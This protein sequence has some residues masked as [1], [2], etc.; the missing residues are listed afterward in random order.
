[1]HCT[2]QTYLLVCL[3]TDLIPVPVSDQGVA[4]AL[5]HEHSFVILI[6]VLR[7]FVSHNVRRTCIQETHCS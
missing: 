7:V 4:V 2:W 1:M 3:L 6:C 5:A